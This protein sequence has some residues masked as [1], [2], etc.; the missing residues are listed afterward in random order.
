MF[1]PFDERNCVTI[2]EGET[3]PT[4]VVFRDRN[5]PGFFGANC[6]CGENYFGFS[7]PNLTAFVKLHEH[8]DRRPDDTVSASSTVQPS[9]F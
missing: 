2:D 8:V 6:A 9:L 5:Y 4:N 1:A 7:L 3:A